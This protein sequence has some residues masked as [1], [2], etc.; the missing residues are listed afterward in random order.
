MRMENKGGDTLAS[1]GV[2]CQ[3]RPAGSGMT[4]A[5]WEAIWDDKESSRS[6][7]AQADGDVGAK[8]G[9]AETGSV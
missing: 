7:D 1:G 6:P 2:R 4:Q 5:E 9:E 8:S 3:F